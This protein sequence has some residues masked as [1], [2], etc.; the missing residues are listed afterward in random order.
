MNINKCFIPL[1]PYSPAVIQ[2]ALEDVSTDIHVS[3]IQ[4]AATELCLNLLASFSARLWPRGCT[5]QAYLKLLIGERHIIPGNGQGRILNFQNSFIYF[6]SP[7]LWSLPRRKPRG[8]QPIL[9]WPHSV[10]KLSYQKR[11]RLIELEIVFKWCSKTA[12]YLSMI[13]AAWR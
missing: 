13:P 10:I 11:I 7:F 12:L 1:P 2:S 4:D 6:P 5:N 3:R 8:D 9:R